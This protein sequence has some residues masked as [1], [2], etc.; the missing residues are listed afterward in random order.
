MLKYIF[1]TTFIIIY[2]LSF[3]RIFNIK[4]SRR[5]ALIMFIGYVLYIFF[6][7]PLVYKIVKPVSPIDG[8]NL[9]FLLLGVLDTCVG[10][11]MCMLFSKYKDTTAKYIAGIQFFSVFNHLCGRILYYP[12]WSKDIYYTIY[13]SISILIVLSIITLMIWPIINGL[14]VKF[15]KRFCRRFDMGFNA[16]GDKQCTPEIEIK[17]NQGRY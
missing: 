13:Q 3:F 16:L 5:P 9:Y 14:Y 4:D 10:L 1:I 6:I 12:G 2:A 11:F 7:H 8:A 15:I 17:E